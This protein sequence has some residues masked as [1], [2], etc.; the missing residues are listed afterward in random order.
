MNL[1]KSI[2]NRV[3]LFFFF[4]FSVSSRCDRRNGALEEVK[5]SKI[6]AKIK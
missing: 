1:D 4:S 3:G 6:C 5:Q 2:L